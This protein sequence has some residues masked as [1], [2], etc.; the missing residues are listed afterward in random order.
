MCAPTVHVA[1]VPLARAG[2]QGRIAGGDTE[3]GRG[4]LS[5]NADLLRA[6]GAMLCHR[7]A[8]GSASVERVAPALWVMALWQLGS[9]LAVIPHP[10]V[11][12]AA[13]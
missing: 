4:H 5:G 3:N 2:R 6:L 12:H 8:W 10:L 1:G 11:A 7:H 9:A 13:R